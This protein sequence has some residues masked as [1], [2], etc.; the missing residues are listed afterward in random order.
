MNNIF[1]YLKLKTQN[2]EAGFEPSDFSLL[3]LDQTPSDVEIT[4]QNEEYKHYIQ[5]CFI[6]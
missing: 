6:Q 3:G 2:K 4:S 1:E 5:L